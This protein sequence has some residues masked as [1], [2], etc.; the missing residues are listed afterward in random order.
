MTSRQTC[1]PRAAFTLIEIM[2]VCAIIGIVMTMAIPSI[3]RQ[4]HP[5]SMQKAVNDIIEACEDARSHA[6]L[7]GTTMKIVLRPGDKTFQVMQASGP[8]SRQRLESKN[9]A[10]EEWRMEE[11][12]AVAAGGTLSNFKLADSIRIEAIGVHRSDATE[13]EVVEVNFYE[14]GTCDEFHI[15]IGSPEGDVRMIFLEVST[16]VPDIET[17]RHKFLSR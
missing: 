4:L 11:K 2:V 14:N 15:V 16:A 7:K 5:E 10:G 9:V 6:V 13:A 3:Y 17:D 8:A 1:Q 12:P